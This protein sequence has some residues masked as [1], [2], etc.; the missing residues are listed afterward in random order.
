MTEEGKN[1][2]LQHRLLSVLQPVAPA[3]TLD[4]RRKQPRT[5]RKSPRK[6]HKIGRERPRFFGFQPPK[7]FE[8]SLPPAR[9]ARSCRMF[10][11]RANPVQNKKSQTKEARNAHRQEGSRLYNP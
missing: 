9:H 8:G 5:A 4:R 11:P 1:Y 3:I 2:T 6:K 7:K 10:F